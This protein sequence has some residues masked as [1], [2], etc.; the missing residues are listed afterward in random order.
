[1]ACGSACRYFVSEHRCGAG[2]VGYHLEKGG[3]DLPGMYRDRVKR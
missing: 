3:Y 2:A 1:M